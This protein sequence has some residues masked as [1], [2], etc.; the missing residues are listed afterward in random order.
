[1]GECQRCGAVG[2]LA[3]CG[4]CQDCAT[5]PV[6]WDRLRAEFLASLDP[7]QVVYIGPEE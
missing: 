4:L 5:P 1:M 6:D 7:D 3:P 2:R